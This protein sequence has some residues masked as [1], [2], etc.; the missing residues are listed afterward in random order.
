LNFEGD[1]LD[2]V[3]ERFNAPLEIKAYVKEIMEL[4]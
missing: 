2:P 4:K 3:V 1:G